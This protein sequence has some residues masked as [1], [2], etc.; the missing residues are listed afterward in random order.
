MGLLVDPVEEQD[1]DRQRLH[2]CRKGQVEQ[3]QVAHDVGVYRA[4]SRT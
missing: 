1:H 2:A 3:G 4:L